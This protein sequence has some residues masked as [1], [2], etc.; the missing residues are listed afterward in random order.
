MRF[1]LWGERGLWGEIVRWLLREVSYLPTYPRLYF[2]VRRGKT[3]FLIQLMLST[4]SQIPLLTHLTA[5]LTL[6]AWA[7]RENT[8]PGIPTPPFISH[9]R[10]KL[11]TYRGR[12]GLLLPRRRDSNESTTT[13]TT[14][15]TTTG[16]CNFD[17]GATDPG[18]GTT[19][20]EWQV[21]TSSSSP[22]TQPLT[23]TTTTKTTTTSSTASAQS[24]GGTAFTTPSASSSSSD[25]VTDPYASWLNTQPFDAAAW[26]GLDDEMM[27]GLMPTGNG[28]DAMSAN[29]DFTW[30]DMMPN[31]GGSADSGGS[32]NAF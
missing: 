30:N 25:Q 21:S 12:G 2:S 28:F 13:T 10:E 11:A 9:L 16:A 19:V 26:Q 32:G 18:P 1:G 17:C 8:K 15:T 24:T 31:Y 29:W 3:L 27:Q 7:A 23:T 22:S 4:L 5:N 6:K 20:Q 14:T